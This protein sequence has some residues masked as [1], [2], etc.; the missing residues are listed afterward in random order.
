MGDIMDSYVGETCSSRLIAVGNRINVKAAETEATFAA[1]LE[2]IVGLA[3]PH[4]ALDRPNLVVLGECLGLPLALSG[5]R[6]TLPRRMRT[7]NVA[8]SMLALGYTRRILYYRR[9]FPGISLVRALL[10][11]LADTL[12]RPFTETL[13][14]LAAHHKIYLCASAITPHVYCS[15]DPVKVARFGKKQ[16]GRVY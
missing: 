14:Q 15:T 7:A 11:S 8:I 10:L 3:V 6:G 4:L 12:Y 9:A 1:E 13:S 5:K 16:V 2:R